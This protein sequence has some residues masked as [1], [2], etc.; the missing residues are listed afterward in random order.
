M[1]RELLSFVDRYTTACQPSSVGRKVIPPQDDRSCKDPKVP[2]SFCTA[3]YG[4]S[5]RSSV[6]ACPCRPLEWSGC[7]PGH[8]HPRYKGNIGC[9]KPL[10]SLE[11]GELVPV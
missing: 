1:K 7:D 2:S 3:Q 11:P 9:V 6:G 5:S 8:G 10:W 4:I